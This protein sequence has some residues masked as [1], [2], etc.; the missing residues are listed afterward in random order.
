MF[1]ATIAC[2]YSHARLPDGFHRKIHALT[3]IEMQ[4]AGPRSARPY[5]KYMNYHP[6]SDSATGCAVT[7]LSH[8]P[9]VGKGAV[10]VVESERQR[11]PEMTRNSHG[12]IVH[13]ENAE[14][15]VKVEC[16]ISSLG[17]MVGDRVGLNT[18]VTDSEMNAIT[19]KMG[20]V[21]IS[22]RKP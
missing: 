4:P 16:D 5:E 9:T 18:K 13:A 17:K 7:I 8:S 12:R 10:F 20:L 11:F 2:T 19:K 6:N 15:Y 22:S 3:N 1:T 14:T 21:I